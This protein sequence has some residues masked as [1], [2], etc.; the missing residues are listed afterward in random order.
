M[1]IFMEQD[2]SGIIDA[3]VGPANRNS[4]PCVY[5]GGEFVCPP[6]PCCFWVPPNGS[7]GHWNCSEGEGE[8]EGDYLC[9]SCTYFDVEL[10][11]VTPGTCPPVPG[12][13]GGTLP[14]TCNLNNRVTIRPISE[15]V[16]C[17]VCT[18]NSG[19]EF[20]TC[21]STSCLPFTAVERNIMEKH[22]DNSKWCYSSAGYSACSR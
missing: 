15:S 19:D 10:R 21:T 7:S 5:E 18:K 2:G 20:Y 3:N 16:I 4:P 14:L 13:G 17:D 1:N 6:S 11:W 9:T 12:P 22:G 8:G